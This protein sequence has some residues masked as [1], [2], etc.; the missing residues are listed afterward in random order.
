[1]RTRPARLDHLADNLVPLLH[2]FQTKW[3]ITV[4]AL[5]AFLI[6]FPTSSSFAASSESTFDTHDH[7][8][9]ANLGFWQGGLVLGGDYEYAYDRTFGLGATARYYSRD[10]DR[11]GTGSTSY[12]IIGGFVRP[13][14]NRRAWDFYVS[15][16]FN[17]MNLD[18]RNNDK[19]LIGPSVNYGLLYQVKRSVAIGIENSQ[20]FCWFDRDYQGAILLDLL[21][22]ARI[23][24]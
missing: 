10:N 2:P 15:P 24:F 9:Y 14:F 18:G 17:I 16:G 23:S 3:K 4:H 20:F 13:H 5:F 1:M 12:F 11:S 7:G 19:T 6:L 21:A 8:A 22:K